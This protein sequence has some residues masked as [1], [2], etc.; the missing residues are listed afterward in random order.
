[1][2]KYFISARFLSTDADIEAST[3]KAIE[4]AKQSGA[5]ISFDPNLRPALWKNLDMAKEKIQYGLS[6]CD[7]LKISDDEIAFITGTDDI[8][9]G[10]N[11]IRKEYD[12]PL[13]CATMGKK[14]SKAY[15]K[16]LIVFC[17]A[18]TDVN[19]VET[20]GAGDTFMACMLDAVLKNG[21]GGF[22]EQK[23]YDMI[24][25]ANAASSIIT[26]RCGALKVVPQKNEVLEFLA[27][28]NIALF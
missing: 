12:I 14:G 8:D 25:F 21:I 19:T 1:M 22:T 20:T 27:K 9:V 23:L 17:A 6:Q 16:N 28:R 11:L 5:I 7:V 10:I 4:T 26:T 18:F 2:E 3:K 15:Y 13:I 24:T